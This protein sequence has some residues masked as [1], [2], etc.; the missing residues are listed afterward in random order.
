MAF[1]KKYL[2]EDRHIS[3]HVQLHRALDELI[4][5]FIDKTGKP[6]EIPLLELIAW[7]YQQ[8]KQ[9]DHRE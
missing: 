9:P 5:D 6:L 8:T 1:I 2:P 4:A 3:R 7:S